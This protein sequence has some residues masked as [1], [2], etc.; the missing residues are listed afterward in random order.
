MVMLQG[1]IVHALVVGPLCHFYCAL[2]CFGSSSVS[3]NVLFQNQWNL[4][5][6]KKKK[7]NACATTTL[8]AFKNNIHVHAQLS[9]SQK[10]AFKLQ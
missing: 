4:F 9:K 2:F 8:C 3:W 6:G 10:H 5:D 7:T 1:T